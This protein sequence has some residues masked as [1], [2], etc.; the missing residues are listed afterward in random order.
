MG[1]KDNFLL[2]QLYAE[3]EHNVTIAVPMFE[4]VPPNYYVSVI[5]TPKPACLYLS[6]ISSYQRNSLL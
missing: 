1:Q 2:L 6:S 5:S 4:P 3:D